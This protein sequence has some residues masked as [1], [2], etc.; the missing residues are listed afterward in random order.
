MVF[1]IILFDLTMSLLFL[2]IFLYRSIFW[3]TKKITFEKVITKSFWGAVN[4]KIES[5]EGNS[6]NILT[7]TEV[8]CTN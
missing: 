8:K 1:T 2:F 6:V 4:K 5:I 3:P 7:L